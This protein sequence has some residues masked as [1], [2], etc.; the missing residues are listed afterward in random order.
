MD[1]VEK[2]I[3]FAQGNPRL[4]SFYYEGGENSL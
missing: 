2:R 4:L 3:C 1:N